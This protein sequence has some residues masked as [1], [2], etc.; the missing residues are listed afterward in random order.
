MTMMFE[1][2]D[3]AVASPATVSRCGMVYMEPLALG[4]EPIYR[5]WLNALPQNLKNNVNF[6]PIL[7][8]LIEFYFVKIIAFM[9]RNMKEI[10]TSIDN[11]L[12]ASCLR[13]M[14]SFMLPWKDTEIKKVSAEEIENLISM[15][16]P[17]FVFSLIWS[18]GCTTDYEVILKFLTF[19]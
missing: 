15:L 11:N 2:E 19:I 5:S 12:V 10:V 3:L 1:V 16:E 9:R 14:D 17:L 4:I 6:V 18:F 7:E 13:I 8:G